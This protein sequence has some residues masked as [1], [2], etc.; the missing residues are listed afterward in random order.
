VAKYAD[1]C[2]IGGINP[3]V[4]R[5]KFSVLKEHCDRQGRDYN[6]II[7]SAEVFTHLILPGKSAEEAT[8]KARRDVSRLVGREVGLEE[9]RENNF[10][11]YPQGFIGTPREAIDT[12]RQLIDAGVEYFIVY[13]SDVVHLDTLRAFAEEVL[14]AFNRN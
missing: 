10:R 8:A 3:D 11:G 1:A 9:F 5:H 14:P 13:L 7:K 4:Y 12:Y 2:N 6:S